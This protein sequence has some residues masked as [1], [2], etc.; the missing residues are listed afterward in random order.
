MDLPVGQGE[1]VAGAA[2]CLLLGGLLGALD[3]LH[4]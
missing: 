3:Y 1:V 4:S 2:F